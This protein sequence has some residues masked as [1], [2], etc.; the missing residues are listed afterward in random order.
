MPVDDVRNGPVK[1]VPVAPRYLDPVSLAGLI[2][3]V[4][5]LAWTLYNDQR[6][7]GQENDQRNR[8]R[9][10]EPQADSIAWQL[11]ITLRDRDMTLSPDTERIT[12]IVATEII[13]Q[14]KQ[15]QE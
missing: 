15:H 12:E 4:A 2:V 3:S 9:E 7:R 8:A 11:R 14:S 13:R 6:N 1:T 5:T 10:E